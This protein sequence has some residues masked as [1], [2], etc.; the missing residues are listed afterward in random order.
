MLEPLSKFEIIEIQPIDNNGR[1]QYVRM[2]E[3][4]KRKESSPK[5]IN[6]IIDYMA[7]KFS[8]S[9]FDME[10]AT[11]YFM[12]AEDCAKFTE[13]DIDTARKLLEK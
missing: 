8:K 12:E 13:I 2:V 3:S 1:A 11:T 6:E 5:L 10:A 4:I 9:F 7:N